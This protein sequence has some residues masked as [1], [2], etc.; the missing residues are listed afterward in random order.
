MKEKVTQEMIDEAM[1]KLL[2]LQRK[3]KVWQHQTT[4]KFNLMVI[5]HVWSRQ[6]N[7]N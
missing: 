6:F 7:P 1:G 2:A 5:T 3:V 4:F